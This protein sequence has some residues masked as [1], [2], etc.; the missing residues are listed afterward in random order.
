M[1]KL[2]LLTP[3]LLTGCVSPIGKQLP[4]VIRELAKDTNSISLRITSPTFG[5]LEF[6]RNMPARER[7]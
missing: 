3:L 5:T 4:L 1:K 6:D 2:I 7:K